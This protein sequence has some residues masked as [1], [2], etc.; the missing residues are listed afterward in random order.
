MV[1]AYSEPLPSRNQ[2]LGNLAER[3][4][5]SLPCVEA[6]QEDRPGRADRDQVVPAVGRPADHR[7]L[8]RGAAGSPDCRG[9]PDDRLPGCLAFQAFWSLP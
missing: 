2:V 4:D 1:A 6:E 9:H 3:S 8:H 5:V 7:G